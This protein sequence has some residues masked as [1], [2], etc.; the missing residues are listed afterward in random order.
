MT[1]N[2]ATAR[3]PS[4]EGAY[5]YIHIATYH[6]T[7]RTAAIIQCKR[8]GAHARGSLIIPHSL[9]FAYPPLYSTLRISPRFDATV[10]G[11]MR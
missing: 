9:S 7:G 5:C 2:G 3:H 1:L 6:G 8:V 11:R 10:I 4:D